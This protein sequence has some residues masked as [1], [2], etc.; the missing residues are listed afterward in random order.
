MEAA[1][2]PPLTDREIEVLLLVAQ[3]AS[4]KDMARRLSISIGGVNFHILNA[5]KKLSAVSRANAVA[6]AIALD[7]ISPK[8]AL[9]VQEAGE[10]HN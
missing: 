7:L 6:K 1:G 10:R 3:G 2:A 9:P 4:S 8:A 5:M